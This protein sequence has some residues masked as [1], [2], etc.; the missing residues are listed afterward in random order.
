M[1]VW[2]DGNVKQADQ[3]CESQPSG[4]CWQHS[5][6]R[7]VLHLLLCTVN[8]TAAVLRRGCNTA[9]CQRLCALFNDAVSLLR[10]L[11][12]GDE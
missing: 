1:C 5:A 8:T 7:D 6:S 11:G 12:V 9:Q 2:I 10:Y 4:W 3:Y